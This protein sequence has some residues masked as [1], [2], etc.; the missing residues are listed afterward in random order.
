MNTVELV[1]HEDYNGGYDFDE[2][3]LDCELSDG[4]W[5]CDASITR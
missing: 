1:L 2:E 3:F 4:S 5:E